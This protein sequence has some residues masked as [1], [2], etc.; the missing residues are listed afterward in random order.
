MVGQEERIKEGMM[1]RS[2]QF[3]E[4]RKVYDSTK[5]GL[6]RKAEEF[7]DGFAKKVKKV[8]EKDLTVEN[9]SEIE[10]TNPV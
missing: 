2:S 1:A 5:I 4:K 3:K 7:N 9:C 8:E 6:Y 10:A